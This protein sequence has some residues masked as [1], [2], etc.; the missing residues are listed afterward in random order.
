MDKKYRLSTVGIVSIVLYVLFMLLNVSITNVTTST[1]TQPA[2]SEV[3][4][5]PM[6]TVLGM[7]M[8]IPTIEYT[9]KS[10]RMFYEGED[11]EISIYSKIL[12][13]LGLFLPLMNYGIMAFLMRDLTK[14]D[15]KLTT[16]QLAG[17]IICTIV[18]LG[19]VWV[20]YGLIKYSTIKI[21]EDVFVF[22]TKM[23]VLGTIGLVLIT[24]FTLGIIW[25]FIWIGI[26]STE[27]L[28]KKAITN[29]QG[30]YFEIRTASKV[31]LVVISILT[32]GIIPLSLLAYYWTYEAYVLAYNYLVRQEIPFN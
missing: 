27:Y 32:V 1:S 2:Y 24:V 29:V 5:H 20:V 30:N 15:E 14:R 26:A 12:T 6:F 19:I 22:D 16:G 18:T 31:I 10:F 9:I 4:N 3:V 11:Y 17:L 21:F 28:V 25:I 23:G 13:V 8:I 7:L